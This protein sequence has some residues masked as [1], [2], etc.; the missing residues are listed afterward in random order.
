MA[1][2]FQDNRDTTGGKAGF[3]AFEELKTDKAYD[4][5]TIQANPGA[6]PPAPV[7]T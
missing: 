1:N 5:E 4:D 2:P 3:G 7:P 6:P